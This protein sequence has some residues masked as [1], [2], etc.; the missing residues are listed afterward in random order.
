MPRFGQTED[1]KNG[2]CQGRRN[3]FGIGGRAKKILRLHIKSIQLC[4]LVYQWFRKFNEL[5]V[6]FILI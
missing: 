6:Y 5:S 3:G 1:L 4:S 2:S